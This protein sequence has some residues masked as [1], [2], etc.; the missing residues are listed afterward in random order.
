MLKE[1]QPCVVRGGSVRIGCGLTNGV[2]LSV[3]VPLRFALRQRISVGYPLG[4]PGKGPGG[5][6]GTILETRLSRRIRFRREYLV[7]TDNGVRAWY[8]SCELSPIQIT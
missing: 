3:C 2:Q 8:D 1:H 7:R 6:H 4:A 5:P